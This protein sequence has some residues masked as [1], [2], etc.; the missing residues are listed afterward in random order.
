[1]LP[2][3]TSQDQQPN[4]PACGMAPNLPS[5]EATR[6]AARMV[7]AQLVA[8]EGDI[9]RLRQALTDLFFPGVPDRS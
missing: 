3:Y 4:P 2:R 6:D 8:I 5:D 1:M 9:K 7:I